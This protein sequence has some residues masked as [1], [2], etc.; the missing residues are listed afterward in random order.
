MYPEEALQGNNKFLRYYSPP[1]V[2]QQEGGDKRS[3]KPKRKNHVNN[4]SEV[5]KIDV[6]LGG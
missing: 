4:I 5:I 3:P 6:F 1:P 2:F